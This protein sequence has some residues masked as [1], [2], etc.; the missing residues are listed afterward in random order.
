MFKRKSS[1]V[2]KNR[3]EPRRLSVSLEGF[4]NFLAL[5]VCK[6]WLEKVLVTIVAL[7]SLKHYACVV[8]ERG[9]LL[10]YAIRSRRTTSTWSWATTRVTSQ[11]AACWPTKT[12]W[13]RGARTPTSFTLS[14]PGTAGV[15][16]WWPKAGGAT[17]VFSSWTPTNASTCVMELSAWRLVEV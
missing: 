13:S 17:A 14:L 9:N 10:I 5:S 15:C 8:V 12:E 6:V 3:I 4:N 2:F 16:C 1:R 7:R 11:C